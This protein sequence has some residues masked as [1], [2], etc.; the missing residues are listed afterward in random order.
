MI[1]GDVASRLD[2]LRTEPSRCVVLTDFDGTLAPIVDDPAAARPLAGTDTVLTALAA[3][4]ADVVVISGRPLDFLTVHLPDTV[5]IVG[6]Y[7]LEGRRHG[8][9]WRHPDAERWRDVVGE[10]AAL[11]AT[12]GPS[13]MRVEPKGLSL[14]LHYRDQPEAATAV[15]R[16]ARELG[17]RSGLEVRAAR[18]SVELHPPVPTDKGTVVEQL[19]ATA[20]VALFAGDDTGDIAAFDALDHLADRGVEGVRVA[21]R[22]DEAPADLLDRADLVVDGPAAVLD[23]FRSLYDTTAS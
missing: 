1:A 20:E 19:A 15:A 6:L 4:L 8:E 12:G 16:F 5:S 3:R 21:V 9:R 13:G 23:L 11:A 18:M 22:S 7:G 2:R 14:T 10:V 17:T